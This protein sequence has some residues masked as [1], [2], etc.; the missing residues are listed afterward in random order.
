ML[1]WR[2]ILWAAML[3]ATMAVAPHMIAIAGAMTC[4]TIAADARV[5]THHTVPA[6]AA[7]NSP[8]SSA[9]ANAGVRKTK[10]VMST[11]QA[12]ASGALRIAS[13]KPN[14]IENCA[15]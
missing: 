2:S 6:H 13:A 7:L 11:P 15:A 4:A 8:A 9:E 14:V 3:V 1:C 10:K 12:A 5:E